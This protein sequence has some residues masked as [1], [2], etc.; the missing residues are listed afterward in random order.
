MIWVQG[1]YSLNYRTLTIGGSLGD[2]EPV[3]AGSD[4][5]EYPCMA[6]DA[7]GNP[8]AVWMGKGF[9]TN[10]TIRQVLYNTRNGSWGSV[11]NV[12]DISTAQA[13][14]HGVSLAT[15][16][17]DDAHVVWS[18]KGWGVNTTI[19]NVQYRKRE[20][21]T[22]QTQVNV[23]DETAGR[24]T[25]RIAVDSQGDAHV[26]YKRLVGTRKILLRSQSS[27]TF[28]AERE[29]VDDS[30]IYFFAMLWHYWPKVGSIQS[31]VL[32]PSKQPVLIW[33]AD[34]AGVREMEMYLE[35]LIP[36]G[37]IYPSNALARVSGL[38]HRFDLRAGIDQ[39]E[40]K[41]GETNNDIAVPTHD[42]DF[43]E[44]GEQITPGEAVGLPPPRQAPPPPA[45]S[46]ITPGAEIPDMN[47]LR[48]GLIGPGVQP[49]APPVRINQ[50]GILSGRVHPRAGLIGPSAPQ[51]E[52]LRRV[53]IPAV[54]QRVAG[55]AP[56]AG[57]AAFARE[58]EELFGR[59][60][61][62][63]TRTSRFAT[64]EDI[65]P[66]EALGLATPSTSRVGSVVGGGL[67]DIGTRAAASGVGE[68][69]GSG[70]AGFR[71]ALARQ[72]R[73]TFNR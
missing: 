58:Q 67:R 4:L 24:L 11:E 41:L 45:P 39:L 20:S 36:A 15:D 62:V 5:A 47:V 3:K 14:N 16:E 29:L 13:S 71:A 8:Q 37:K 38:I 30:W 17:N 9:G 50:P 6:V 2:V 53:A 55:A 31:G 10:S 56:R 34:T 64:G 65:T 1:S 40:M 57:T 60:T 26:Q 44:S 66:G 21:S 54:P 61:G 12:T 73:R 51:R 35:V 22:W 32:S 27:G 70:L 23:T 69:I 59:G 25:P 28:D 42:R 48:T 63:I 68:V 49:L 7:S 18:G 46:I 72:A 19:N 33:T 43:F 52:G